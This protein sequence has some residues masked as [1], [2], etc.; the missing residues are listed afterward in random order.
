MSTQKMIFTRSA[1]F[2]FGIL[3]AAGPRWATAED[4]PAVPRPSIT[5][6]RARAKLLHEAFHA[7][8][9][10]VH[11]RYYREDEGLI[12][13]AKTLEAV[14]RELER[15]CQ[16]KVRWLAVNAQPMNVNHEAKDDFERA[17]VKA[18]TEG[19]QEYES[20]EK[21]N[22]RHVGA[23]TLTAECLKC[24]VPHRTSLEDRMAGLSISMMIEDR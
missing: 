11:Q 2:W 22:Y 20:V 12:I 15:S 19:K 1:W 10:I 18:L 7:T 5:E 9:H 21:A 23:I 4:P 24:H 13:P 8:L 16:V 3:V 6:A 17:A 14:F